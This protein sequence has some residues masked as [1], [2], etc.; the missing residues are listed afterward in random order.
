MQNR[1]LALIVLAVCKVVHES[2]VLCNTRM[3]WRWRRQSSAAFTHLRSPTFG[4]FF[5]TVTSSLTLYNI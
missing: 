4:S 1:E 5:S 2:V 3:S